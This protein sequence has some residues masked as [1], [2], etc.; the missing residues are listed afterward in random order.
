M[1]NKLLKL[2]AGCSMTL[3]L[4]SCTSHSGK[5]PDKSHNL[6]FEKLPQRWDEAIP[7]GNGIT[8]ALLWQKDGKLRLGLDRTDL[9]DLRPVPQFESPDYSFR[10]LCEQVLKKKSMEPVYRI[11]DERTAKDAAPTKIPAGA[12]EFDVAKLGVVRN[13][14]L[15]LRTAT[16]SVVWKNG[17]TATFFVSA[18]EKGGRFCFENLPESLKPDLLAPL[19]EAQNS[20]KDSQPGMH[21]LSVLHYH[22]GKITRVE[23]GYI[24]YRQQAWGD[25]SYEIALKW[26]MTDKKTLTGEYCIISKGTAYSEPE[27][28]MESM[29]KMSEISYSQSMSSH[30]EWWK[31]Y[32]QKSSITLPDSILE[33]QWYLEMYKF[34]A[35]SRKGAPPISL[36][37]IW[38]AD[39]GQ[40]PPWRGDFHHDLNTEMSYWPGYVANHLDESAVFTDWL[41]R[42]K[43]NA[44]KFTQK[45]FGVRGLNVPGVTTLTGEALG[46][47]SAYS[48]S[49]TTAGWLAHHFYLQWKYSM[50]RNFLQQEAYP[51]VKEVATYFTQISVMENG[52][53]RLPLS[54]S[55]EINDNK[56][57]A[58]FHQTTNY[59][60][61][62]I[63]LT[64]RA[65]C[66]MAEALGLSAEA[67]QW[68]QVLAQWPEPA[69]NET[70]LLIAPDYPLNESHRHFSHLLA[71]YP[72]GQIDVSQG[73]EKSAL[74][75][76][77]L[78]HIED[79]GTDWWT[80]FS[81]AWMANMK[82]RV[83][84]GNGALRNLHIFIRAF[85][86][87]N[88][89]HL[90]GDQTQS[91][92]SN[93][94]YRPF[95][96]E[97]NFACASAIQ[98]MLL[99][100]HTG[101]IR[102]F[103]A[104]PKKWRNASFTN[105]RAMGAFL[106]SSEFAEGRVSSLRV[107]S[108]K[109]GTLTLYNPFT[110]NIMSREMSP[111]EVVVLSKENPE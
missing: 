56:L 81:Y 27:T 74:I 61:A 24:V 31:K 71:F 36:Q 9:W 51:W 18:N 83:F 99:Q 30:T 28:A 68:K 102:V 110:N 42:I 85:C 103:P 19:Y 95:T 65:A 107:E 1:N 91:G 50:D 14:T 29:K 59:D 39:N 76:R 108:E 106:V 92:Y 82:A 98:E 105:L 111:G 11:I 2:I 44:E 15:D 93:F 101:V 34:G 23:P 57:N 58:W 5:L 4:F 79:M 54:T 94:T 52:K 46:G 16:A 80:G 13:A 60:L 20:N 87:P 53:R 69:Y 72:F 48:H 43:G 26:K 41:W 21:Q 55:P 89:F 3:V 49:P 96:L 37:A 33:R 8:G 7:L 109:G 67:K 78:K 100:S 17:V 25:V 84:D 47:W 97:G 22:T 35:A 90:N 12:I 62:N 6:S 88:S 75:L 104:M 77:S 70:G 63:C 86:S 38:S 10:F 45:F 40:T 64:F 73:N 32:W 66:E